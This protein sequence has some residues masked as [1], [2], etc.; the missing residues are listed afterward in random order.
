MKPRSP[1]ECIALLSKSLGWSQ[2]ALALRLR[3]S[4]S[5]V[6]R[7]YTGVQTNLDYKVVDEMREMI[8]NAEAWK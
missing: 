7:V 4:Q 3:I 1:Q 6:S 5:T 2:T 8:K